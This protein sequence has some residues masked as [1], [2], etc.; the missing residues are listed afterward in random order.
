MS[1]LL[2]CY[3]GDPPSLNMKNRFFSKYEWED[4]GSDGVNTYASCDEMV[5]M[6]IDRMHV[7]AEN[8]DQEAK[9]F[10]IKV[11]EIVFL[12]RHSSASNKPALTVHAIGN[13]RD[14][15]M[16][17]M[18]GTLVKAT[19]HT[20][21][22]TLRSIKELNNNSEY[23]V[24][25]EVTHH[26]P[27]VNVPTMYME[28][29]SDRNRWTDIRAADTLVDA[30]L[31]RNSENY[32][33][34]VGIGGGHYAPRFSEMAFTYKVDFGHMI[35]TYQLKGAT[36]DEIIRMISS[37]VRESSAD[38]IYIHHNSIGEPEEKRIED[39]VDSLGFE[40]ISSRN[41]DRI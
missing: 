31:R 32:M 15:Q 22:A 6:T 2:V 33:V 39:L 29:G 23:S 13:Y 4:I 7:F 14:N 10:G 9:N 11:D 27:F 38:V 25:F 40:R 24:S 18:C 41:V 3:D 34:A 8:I 20:M 35:P 17:G 37:A 30:F 1:I 26:G 28:I 19:P 5:M 36:D 12:S 21:T 16:G